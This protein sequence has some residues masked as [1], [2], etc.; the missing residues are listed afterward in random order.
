MK[1]ANFQAQSY[2][3]LPQTTLPIVTPHL[4]C[5]SY[6]VMWFSR[7]VWQSLAASPF[8]VASAKLPRAYA[9]TFS[10]KPRLVR[11]Q[12]TWFTGEEEITFSPV[13]STHGGVG[14]GWRPEKKDETMYALQDF[15]SEAERA[16]MHALLERYR[17]CVELPGWQHDEYSLPL[18]FHAA[19]GRA[20][21]RSVARESL[22]VFPLHGLRVAAQQG[23]LLP[24]VTLR[25]EP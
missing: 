6:L 24:T 5:R 21:P 9:L 11:Y 13:V 19:F 23:V 12:R 14:I 17:V 1:Y 15:A 25:Q 8:A 4:P 18:A 10:G 3:L 20:A 7:R 16:W 2:L 22:C